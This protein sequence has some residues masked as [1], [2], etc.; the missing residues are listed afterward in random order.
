MATKST[1]Q[2]LREFFGERNKEK[3]HP[4]RRADLPTPDPSKSKLAFEAWNK[5][6][7]AT[8]M[9]ELKE[10]TTEERYELAV[11]IAKQE[12]LTETKGPNGTQWEEKKAA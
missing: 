2:V 4:G 8:F 10:L 12:G 7:P 5:A 11:L 3:P 9:D 1:V 6:L